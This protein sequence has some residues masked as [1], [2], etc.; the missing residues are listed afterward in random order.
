MWRLVLHRRSCA[1]YA[2]KDTQHAWG[3]NK[4]KE[5]REAWTNGVPYPN[6]GST[7][8]RRT[9]CSGQEG[10]NELR[11]SIQSSIFSGT[12][13]RW[14]GT[15][16]PISHCGPRLP[17]APIPFGLRDAGPQSWRERK[18]EWMYGQCDFFFFFFSPSSSLLDR[19]V[20]KTPKIQLVRA[21][22]SAND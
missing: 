20:R 9:C 17:R 11:D 18:N 7:V 13:A 22:R 4:K 21:S 16:W 6:C 2:W 19:V 14:V 5:R 12:T 10:K 3:T 1:S 8:D 15:S